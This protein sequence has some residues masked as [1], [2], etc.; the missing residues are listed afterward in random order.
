MHRTTPAKFAI[1]D[2]ARP[3][4]ACCSLAAEQSHATDRPQYFRCSSSDSLP[5]RNAGAWM[6]FT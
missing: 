4:T 6:E 1:A 5:D 2:R 3:P